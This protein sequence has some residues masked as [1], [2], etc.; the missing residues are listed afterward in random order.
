[1][2]V[3]T[4]ESLPAATVCPGCHAPIGTKYILLGVPVVC[5]ACARTVVAKVPEGV[6][7]PRTGY[8]VT[9]RDFY[10]LLADQASL[11]AVQSLI[12]NWFGYE[13]SLIGGNA[14]IRASGGG[15]V[16]ALDLHLLIQADREKQYDLYQAAMSIW[17]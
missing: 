7:Y 16:E 13:V 11:A 17:R 6:P 15:Q 9:F 4:N 10:R 1:M 8:Q 5:E 3:P 14:D 2:S 12:R